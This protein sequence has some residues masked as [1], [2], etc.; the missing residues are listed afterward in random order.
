MAWY[1]TRSSEGAPTPEPNLDEAVSY[2]SEEVESSSKN[3]LKSAP[4]EPIDERTKHIL[5]SVYGYEIGAKLGS[6]AYGEVSAPLGA[7]CL[8]TYG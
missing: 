4:V 6:G 1:P 5:S 7:D 3:D 8:G 2:F